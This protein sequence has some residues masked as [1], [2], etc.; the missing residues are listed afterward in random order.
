MYDTLTNRRQIT[1]EPLS[2]TQVR[3]VKSQVRRYID[4]EAQDI[5]IINI[6]QVKEVF[7]QF[8]ILVKKAEEKSRAAEVQEK[9]E[10]TLVEKT[11]TP[12]RGR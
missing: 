3:E 11:E 7:E 9:K 10:V 6:R 1:Y 12:T 4:G 8:K 2:E 5:E